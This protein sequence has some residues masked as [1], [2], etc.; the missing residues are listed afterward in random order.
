M[1]GSHSIPILFALLPALTT[2]TPWYRR[3][4]PGSVI[5]DN[6]ESTLVQQTSPL[7]AAG[8]TTDGYVS[9]NVAG[10][11][12]VSSLAS[13][14][15]A[16]IASTLVSSVPAGAVTTDMYG[17]SVVTSEGAAS[18]LGYVSGVAPD[19]TSFK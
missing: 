2:A 13:Y 10:S 18:S 11:T 3:E 6:A 5:S 16:S 8:A 9:S 15:A 4:T 7:P 17:S 19:G 1:L 14:P 12:I